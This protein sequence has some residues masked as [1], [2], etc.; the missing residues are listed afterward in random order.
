MQREGDP[1]DI[2]TGDVA[3]TQTD[4][5]LPG[6]LPLVLQRVHRSSQRGG[7]WFG[8]SWISSLDQRILVM[9]DRI[10]CVLAGGQVLVY[11]RAEIDGAD[12][13]VL[14]VTGPSWRLARIDDGTYTVT[15]A[16][17]GL[18]WRFEAH[19][20]YWRYA[21]G[22]GEYPL[23]SMRDRAGHV[24]S[25]EY[26][27]AGEPVSMTHS[28]GYRLLVAMTGNRVAALHLS[29]PAL[30]ETPLVR[31]SYDAAGQLTEIINSSGQPLRL[32][33][34]DAGRVAGYIDRN[35]TSYLYTYDSS[36]RCVRGESPDGTLSATYEY[37]D[38][39]TLWTNATGAVTTYTIDRSARIA[40]VTDPLGGVTRYTHDARGRVTSETDPLGRVTE[41]AFDDFGNLV[42]VTRPD[43]AVA[44]A[45]YD[46]LCQPVEVEEPGRGVWR[47]DF[48]DRGNRISLTQPD[49]S[50]MRFAYDV[51]GHLAA[52]TGA[53]GA[54]T[55][56]ACDA[57][58]LPVSVTAPDGAVTRYERDQ[59]GRIGRII[60]PDGAVTSMEWTTEGWP[61][62]RTFQDGSVELWIWGAE[63][64]LIR[65]VSP[66]GASSAYEYGPFDKVTS[67][68][69]P[70][71][72]RTMF[73]YDGELRLTSVEHGG[74]TWSYTYDA[75]GRVVGETDYNGAPTQY[76]LDTAGQVVRRLNAVGQEVLYTYDV[77]GNVVSQTI[78]GEAG[79]D[80]T[81]LE[82]D[83]AGELVLARN[84]S[85]EVVFERDVFRR[86]TAESCDGRLVT[87]SYDAAGR[88]TERVTPS[89]AAS[90]WTYDSSGLPVSLAAGGQSLRF[91]HGPSSRETSRELPGGV[92]LAQGW[93]ALGRLTGQMLTGP[94]PG[95]AAAPGAGPG[96][97]PG[98]PMVLQWR[99]YAYNP[100]GYVTGISDLMTGS[101][102]FSLDASGRVTTATGA[103]WAE[104]YAY[105]PV[106]N[107][108][109]ASWPAVPE[110]LAG[111]WLDATPQ[112]ARSVSGTLTRQAGNI[113]YRYDA[114]GRVVQRTRTRLSR[115]PETWRYEWDADNRLVAVMTPDGS[116]WRYAY[117][118]LGRRVR[119][120]RVSADGTVMA[121]TRFT[122]DGL[123]LAEQAELVPD[124]SGRELVTTWDYRPGSF[125][126]LTQS[127]RT[128]LRDAPQGVID[129]EFY[130]IITDL[131][132][133]PSELVASN[134]ALVGFQQHTL[135]GG[136]FWH[137]DGVSTPLRFPGQ[138]AD[139]ETGL[140]YNNQRYYDP[141]SGAYLSPDPLGLP[142]A[143][144][145]HAYVPNPHVLVDPLGLMADD[146]Y[147][148]RV[149]PMAS[150]W[151]TKGAH[152][153]I[154]GN[155]VRVFPDGSGGIGAEPIR[156]ST[157]TATAGQVQRVLDSLNSSSALRE[158]L[159]SK[160]TSAMHEMNAH[161]WGN[162][163]NR[164]AEMNFL[165]KALRR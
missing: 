35:A 154:G 158:D 84:A 91:G 105:D 124:G 122:W 12:S 96:S 59:F 130:A 39:K 77:L 3:L 75:A 136:T 81:L 38:G 139:D 45:A 58:G 14:P 44:R 109:S 7:R 126:P 22:Q 147:N 21:G 10:V 78:S 151:A 125:T 104:H 142:P 123:V 41:Y 148:V 145:P 155:E 110:S 114:A 115:K 42:L 48:D 37:R 152:V 157:G 24:I 127:T 43:G 62:T 112:G 153:H 30:G 79:D 94:A 71:G 92:K 80:V 33:Y 76:E 55:S 86:I 141:V 57:L 117:D 63:G 29:N 85:A 102:A 160:A 146:S 23:A 47:Q 156:L 107:V 67:M 18:T 135:W 121:E 8:E 100:D 149:S 1:V 64:N 16:Q 150:D 26:G 101:R 134:G 97:G 165:I 118:P 95:S 159:I 70:D 9:P 36:G 69:G 98:A 133:T 132:G 17:R 27:T 19:P 6:T 11:R 89:G 140:H 82:Y 46:D 138:Y 131:S 137:P 73:G 2:V 53:D 74:L 90:T 54:V 128:S 143:P 32:S 20:A 162:Y 56:V 129:G 120:Q 163:I 164:A 72:T 15:D 113:R 52:V 93:D 161:N 87:T 106:G 68:T 119:K 13:A 60:D 65:H 108:V 50:M 49:G 31:Y 144:N 34:D 25:F 61:L 116:T 111:G 40:A 5:S 88:V 103:E 28:G 83:A 51:A 4:V 99:Q 66:A